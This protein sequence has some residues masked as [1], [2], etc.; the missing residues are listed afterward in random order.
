ME[1]GNVLVPIFQFYFWDQEDHTPTCI[2]M[3]MP[4]Y[5]THTSN[6]SDLGIHT[7]EFQHP[8]PETYK[9]I[10]NIKGLFK[11]RTSQGKKGT[12]ICK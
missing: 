12:F 8:S 1:K 2:C 6:S 7:H 3:G 9:L 5:K 11:H 4:I 10:S